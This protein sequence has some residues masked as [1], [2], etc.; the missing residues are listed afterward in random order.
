LATF[1]ELGEFGFI[2]RIAR[3]GLADE[4]RVIC[5]IGDDCA[6]FEGANGRVTLV[7]TDLMVEEVHF[8]IANADA[9]RLG[10]KL[11]SVNLSDIAA[12][13]GEPREAL[14]SVAV[15]GDLEVSFVEGIY[16]GLHAL[17][18]QHNVNVVGGDTTASPGPL[19]LNLTLIGEMEKDKV[20][21]RSVARPGDLFY[22][23]GT[24][25]DSLAGLRLS[26]GET[27]TNCEED[28]SYLL[29]RHHDPT[30]RVALGQA[31]ALSGAV[32]AMLD[33][34]DGLSSD[35]GH[36]CR[37]SEVSAVVRSGAVPVSDE[38]VRFCEGNREGAV[39]MGLLGGEDYELLFT[40]APGDVEKVEALSER[41]GHPRLARI[42]LIEAGEGEVLL[43]SEEGER[44][45]LKP[46]GSHHF[47]GTT[48]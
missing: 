47:G 27:S 46:E 33:L 31:L 18:D 24:I 38:L 16:S 20:C 37:R 22:L 21:Y 25:G 35:L 10:R 5:G 4:N 42:G 23:S 6:V 7:T 2:D 1:R 32:T 36:I 30:P 34:S 45:V 8:Q 26:Q 3:H 11:L 12:M 44:S 48:G 19:V 43:E 17:A 15:T 39:E 28:R 40:V 41:G 14:V 29:G 9:E 13:G